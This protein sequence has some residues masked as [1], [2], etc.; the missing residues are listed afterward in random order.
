MKR[1]WVS[2]VSKEQD[3]SPV[4]SPIHPCILGWWI[5]G[6]FE[7]LDVSLCALIEAVD[8]TQAR[9]AI[10]YEWPATSSRLTHKL[11]EWRFFEEKSTDWTPGDRFP[12]TCCNGDTCCNG[13]S[14]TTITAEDEIGDEKSEN[15]LPVHSETNSCPFCGINEQV[16]T[17][18][19]SVVYPYG[20]G[21]DEVKLPVTILVYQCRVCNSEWVTSE[22]ESLY[23]VAVCEYLKVLA[24]H[25]ITKCRQNANLT[26]S[27]FAALCTMG[28]EELKEYEKGMRIQSGWQDV[29][30]YLLS[31]PENIERLQKRKQ[32][33][34]RYE[35]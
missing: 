11:T 23:H 7:N 26:Y 9:N 27:E 6:T 15:R 1:F 4:H 16:N 34:G 8:E 17:G 30:L 12:F 2:W 5:S 32:M 35:Q 19:R 21:E 28:V 18:T 20:T 22:S 33:K 25:R 14:L 10:A 3:S 13:N 31:F 29:V 24:P